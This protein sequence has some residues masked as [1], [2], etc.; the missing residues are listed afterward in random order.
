MKRLLIISHTGHQQLENGQVAGWGPTI[1]EINFLSGHWDEIVHIAC[2]EKTAPKGSS[3]PYTAPNIRFV[4][5][6]TFGGKKLSQKADIIWKAPGILR[7]IS[8][9][10]KGT[11]A[12]QLRLPM[13]IGLFLLPFFAFQYRR[14]YTLWVKYANNWGAPSP[15]PGYRLQRWLL[16]QNFTRCKVTI[17]GFWPKQQEHCLSFENPCLQEKEIAD[18][19]EV[20]LAKP[21]HPPFRL[22]FIGRLEKEKGIYEFLDA[23]EG[24]DSDLTLIRHID[25]VGAGP[26]EQVIRARLTSKIPYTLHGFL[27]KEKV[28]KILQDAHFLVLPSHSEGF[29][30]VIAEAAAFGVIPVVSDVGSIPHYIQHEEN[31]YVGAFKKGSITFGSVLQQALKASPQKRVVLKNRLLQLAHKFTFERYAMRI[32]NEILNPAACD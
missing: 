5:I 14:P 22:I 27:P 11:S 26:L 19:A 24:P 28:F 29:P 7:T 2:L 21:H 15:P 10:L 3:L 8:N 16:K 12:V 4:P 23:L 32:E 25:F 18:F 6:P 31:G 1:N 9:E 13:G 17:N 20:A 30:K